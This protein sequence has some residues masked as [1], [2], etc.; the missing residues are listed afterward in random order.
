M[1][2][3]L[4]CA[5]LKIL[6]IYYMYDRYSLPTLK[7]SYILYQKFNVIR[8]FVTIIIIT[9]IVFRYCVVIFFKSNR[10]LIVVNIHCARWTLVL[11]N[12]SSHGYY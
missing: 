4:S 5:L 2:N 6:C 1:Y 11:R 8:Y 10:Y 9:I 7:M 12:I 3:G